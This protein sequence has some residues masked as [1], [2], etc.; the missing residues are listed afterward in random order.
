MKTL[1]KIVEYRRHYGNRSGVAQL[2]HRTWIV[3]LRHEGHRL[4][5]TRQRVVKSLAEAQGLIRRWCAK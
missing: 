5:I 2:L 3:K 1:G 4:S